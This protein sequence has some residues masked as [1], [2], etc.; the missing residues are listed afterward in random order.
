MTA[1]S[2]QRFGFLIILL[3]VYL[4]FTRNRAVDPMYSFLIISGFVIVICGLLAHVYLSPNS[5]SDN[6]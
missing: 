4:E 5:S 3:G 2:I 6:Q 1:A